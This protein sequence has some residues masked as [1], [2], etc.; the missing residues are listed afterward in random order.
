MIR[1]TVIE[2]GG[3]QLEPW[4]EIAVED[5]RGGLHTIE[6]IV[7]TGFTDKLTLPTE[8]IERLGL[9]YIDSREVTLADGTTGAYDYYQGNVLWHGNLRSAA[10]IALDAD[11]LLGTRM[12]MGSRLTVEFRDGGEVI[13]A[14]P[15]SAH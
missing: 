13:I 9:P 4:V 14:E 1:G 15:P 7:D 3:G 8:F 2:G 5:R 10:V 12:L 6:V 11:P